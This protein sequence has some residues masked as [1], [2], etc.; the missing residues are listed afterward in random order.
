MI[1]LTLAP[2]TTVRYEGSIV[3][4]RG[5]YGWVLGPDSH[6]PTRHEVR[7]RVNQ[8]NVDLRRVR[9]SSLVVGENLHTS[10]EDRAIQDRAARALGRG[11]A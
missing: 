8:R 10:A 3:A 2:G 11:W 7:L 6:D 5:V 1:P 9:L 4:L